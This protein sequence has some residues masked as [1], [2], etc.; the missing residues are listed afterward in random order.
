[1][2]EIINEINPKIHFKSA[3]HGL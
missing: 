3:Y 2:K 1:M